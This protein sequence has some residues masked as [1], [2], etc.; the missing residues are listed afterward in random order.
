MSHNA[1]YK[2]HQKPGGINEPKVSKFG[3]GETASTFDKIVNSK[4]SFTGHK[5]TV[6]SPYMTMR[7]NTISEPENSDIALLKNWDQQKTM[8]IQRDNDSS[9]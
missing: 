4:S 8:P 1:H 9:K 2:S 6:Q 5:S 3:S 7:Q